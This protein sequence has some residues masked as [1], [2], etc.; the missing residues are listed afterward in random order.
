MLSSG[1]TG[2]TDLSTF[3][4][5]LRTNDAVEARWSKI[6]TELTDVAKKV[7]DGSIKMINVQIGEKLGLPILSNMK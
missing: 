3:G 1:A 6:K 7:T 5:A 2:I 4:A